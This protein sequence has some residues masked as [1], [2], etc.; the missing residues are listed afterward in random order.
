M[1]SA[2]SYMCAT[3]YYQ[4]PKNRNLKKKVVTRRKVMIVPYHVL[5]NGSRQ[6]VLVQDTKTNEWG[7]VSGGVKLHEDPLDAAKRELDEETSSTIDFSP[8]PMS[9]QF[10]SLYRPPELKLVDYQRN[11]VVRSVYTIFLFKIDEAQLDK[12]NDFR[13]NKE[14][15][16][17]AC[18]SYENFKGTW[19]FCDD[20]Y[21]SHLLC[22]SHVMT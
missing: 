4:I 8:K 11:E 16:N 22:R 7:F 13:P 12:I 2:A 10:V 20:V 18:D 14:V 17:I 5:R 1:S 6:M 19:G 21:N 3:K 15:V 9:F